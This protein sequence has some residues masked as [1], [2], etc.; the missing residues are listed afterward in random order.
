MRICIVAAV[1]MFIFSNSANAAALRKCNDDS[2]EIQRRV[3]AIVSSDELFAR[4]NGAVD[5]LEYW[6]SICMSNKI[7]ESN[8]LLIGELL[9][10]PEL[11]PYVPIMINEIWKSAAPISEQIRI[12][13]NTQLRNFTALNSNVSV[14]TGDADRS[15]GYLECLND[16]V[17]RNI[18][19]PKSCRNLDLDTKRALRM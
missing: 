6:P 2:Q 18:H 8:V 14:M 13:Y 12:A 1:A 16:R 9:K 19:S 3:S 17:S 10:Y 4:I 15:I 7:K 5:M 11:R